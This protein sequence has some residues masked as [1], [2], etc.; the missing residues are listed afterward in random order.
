MISSLGKL[1]LE[2]SDKLY[3][4]AWLWIFK[5]SKYFGMNPRCRYVNR[6]FIGISTNAKEIEF[7]LSQQKTKAIQKAVQ[8][9]TIWHHS[10]TLP[11]YLPKNKPPWLIAH[12]LFSA[13]YYLVLLAVG[14]VKYCALRVT[15][16]HGHFSFRY[17]IEVRRFLKSFVW[18]WV[19]AGTLVRVE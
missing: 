1:C 5:T 16:S 2:T 9:R 10:E 18:F 3:G 15:W 8:N 12:H 7:V 14:E 19:I 17:R 11:Y 13:I 4:L 6:V